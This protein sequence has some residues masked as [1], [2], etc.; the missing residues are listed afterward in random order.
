M[1][2]RNDIVKPL[3]MALAAALTSSFAAIPAAAQNGSET[4][5]F[6]TVVGDEECPQSTDTEIV[7]CNRYNQDEQYRVP[8]DLRGNPDAPKNQSWARRV[9]TMEEAGDSG[10]LSC[11]PDGLGGQTG[12]NQEMIEAYYGN[13]DRP[14]AGRASEIINATR[15]ERLSDI[16]AEAA[17]EEA[18]VQEAIERQEALR[19]QRDADTAAQQ[20][21]GTT[22]DREPLAVPSDE[23]MDASPE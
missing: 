13:K 23:L 2:N 22:S 21:G 14:S 5:R 9:E 6:V 19:A 12:C 11:S 1:S 17:A 3:A 8:E 15:D 10:A 20:N 4:V 7:V 18:R 16:D